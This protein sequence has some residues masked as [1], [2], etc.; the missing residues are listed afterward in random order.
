MRDALRR[1]LV[2]LASSLLALAATAP[3]VAGGSYGIRLLTVAGIYALLALGYQLVFGH[4]GALSLA[5]GAFFGI[6]AYAT[7]ILAVRLGLDGA[8]TA[9]ASILLPAALAALVAAPVLR[10]ESHYF[11]LATLGLAQ[12]ALLVAINA[13]AM[14]GG[15]NGLPGVP[16]LALLGVAVAKGWPLLAV[17]WSAVAAVAWLAWRA[18]GGRRALVFRLLREDPIAAEALGID[19]GRLRFGAFLFA[20]AAAGLAGALHAHLLGVVSPEVLEFPVLVACLSMVVIGGRARVAGAVLGAMLLVHLP[21]ALRDIGAWYMVVYGGVL[22]AV[23]VFAPNGIVGALSRGLDRLVPGAPAP[24]PVPVAPPLPAPVPPSRP[25]LSLRGATKRFGG[26]TALDAVDLDVAAGEMLG[27]IG[28]NGS[29][30]TTL[31]NVMSGLYRPEAGVVLLA[32]ARIDGEP[33][34]RIARAGVAR[35]FQAPRL[36]DDAGVL[37]NVALGVREHDAAPGRAMHWLRRL[38][39]EDVAR[40]RCG[41]L[42]GGLRRRVEIARAMASAPRLLLLDEPAAG[43]TPQ[44]QDT[45]AR[46]LK[47]LNGEGVTVVVVEHAVAFLAALSTRLVCLVEGRIV[48]EGPPGCVVR[49]PRVVAAYLGARWQ[50]TEA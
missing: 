23:I 37:D 36:I 30:K 25:V 16:G 12:L 32:G 2:P 29:G 27:I 6:G 48:A 8:L 9:P 7:G 39:L 46:A 19:T 24:L 41:D 17:V 35:G 47:T 10:L 43:L 33:P 3:F 28:P 15:A 4:A 14:T 49:D 50:G 34:F 40:R 20:A 42:P 45:L 38:G 31:V 13:E 26:L 18:T 44:E 5:Q 22:L 21:E 1:S 11:A